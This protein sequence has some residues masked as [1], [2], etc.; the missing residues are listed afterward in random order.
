MG[1]IQHPQ[2]NES[3]FLSII[4]PA[5]DLETRKSAVIGSISSFVHFNNVSEVKQW[6]NRGSKIY[7]GIESLDREM[8]VWEQIYKNKSK[9]TDEELEDALRYINGESEKKGLDKIVL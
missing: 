8:Y 7:E 4:D 5:D 1:F 6:H 9:W 2:P 3:H